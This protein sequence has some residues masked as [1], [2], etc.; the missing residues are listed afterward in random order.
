[1]STAK[2]KLPRDFTD[3]QVARI[4]RSLAV[5]CEARPGRRFSVSF[6]PDGWRASL[7]ENRAMAGITMADAMAQ[8]GQVAALEVSQ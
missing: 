7:D 2:K 6:T 3:K 1:M 8:I 5:W 4:F